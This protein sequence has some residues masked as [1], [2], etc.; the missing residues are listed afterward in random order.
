[1]WLETFKFACHDKFF[2]CVCVKICTNMKNKH[3]KGIFDHLLHFFKWKNQK[4]FLNFWKSYCDIFL[5]VLVW[6]QF[7]WCSDRF[8]KHVTIYCEITFELLVIDLKSKKRGKKKT[9][10]TNYFLLQQH[11][12]VLKNT[13]LKKIP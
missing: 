8:L 12:D 11:D 10:M 1:M 3:E 2:F 6:L 9:T 5:L 13:F 7:F 4:I